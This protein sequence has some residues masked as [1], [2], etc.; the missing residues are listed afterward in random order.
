MNGVF[1]RSLFGESSSS[2]VTGGGGGLGGF[3]FGERGD[4]VA[5]S[6]VARLKADAQS[7]ENS[8]KEY[9]RDVLPE[10]QVAGMAERGERRYILDLDDLRREHAPMA[11]GLLHNAEILLPHLVSSLNQY[12][13]EVLA[14]SPDP[15]IAAAEVGARWSLGFTGSFAANHVCFF[16]FSFPLF[17][18][19]FPCTHLM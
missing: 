11:A 2:S 14:R 6:S 13:K 15:K 16:F 8:F 10:E 12:A 1:G 5:V 18:L 4:A 3:G 9:L 7:Y 17:F 19:S